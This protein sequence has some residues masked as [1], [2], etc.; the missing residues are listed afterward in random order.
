[1]PF[2]L[3]FKFLWF[4]MVL[5]FIGFTQVSAVK[6][7]KSKKW[8]ANTDFRC[9]PGGPSGPYRKRIACLSQISPGLLRA[10]TTRGGDVE[11]Q[12]NIG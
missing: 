12:K 4:E 9:E 5:F 1:M 2:V 8:A 10:R 6:R 3:S 11:E 7:S